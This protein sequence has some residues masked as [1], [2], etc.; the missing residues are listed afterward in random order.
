[1]T[2]RSLHSGPSN[3]TSTMKKR[4]GRS[5]PAWPTPV[6]RVAAI[7]APL[8]QSISRDHARDRTD[9]S[10]APAIGPASR[11]AATLM[12]DGIA[13]VRGAGPTLP[14]WEMLERVG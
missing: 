13:S 3:G 2:G 14:L 5:Q 9:R 4:F 12:L 1:M 11:T 7:G 6:R 8:A 10:A